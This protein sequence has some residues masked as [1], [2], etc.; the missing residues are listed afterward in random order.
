MVDKAEGAKGEV[1]VLAG[2]RT[3]SR[4]LPAWTK[5]QEA[6]SPASGPASFH[7]AGWWCDAQQVNSETGAWAT[8]R[9]RTRRCHLPHGWRG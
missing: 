9:R 8:A 2:G 7:A 5:R 1:S 6:T 4:F 3:T